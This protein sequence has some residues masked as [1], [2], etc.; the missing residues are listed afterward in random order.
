MP[1]LRLSLSKKPPLVFLTNR[2][3]ALPTPWRFFNGRPHV[4]N[5]HLIISLL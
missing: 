1:L 2:P 4:I 5:T 3:T